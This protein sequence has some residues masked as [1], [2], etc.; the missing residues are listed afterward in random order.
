[1]NRLEKTGWAM[2]W[3]CVVAMIGAGVGGLIGAIVFLIWLGLHGDPEAWGFVGIFLIIILGFTG[4]T[5][6]SF[7]GR[8]R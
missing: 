8:Q 3:V 2:I 4:L 1:V 6:I 5:L 7:G